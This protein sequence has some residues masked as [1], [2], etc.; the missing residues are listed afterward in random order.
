VG[1]GVL[2]WERYLALD[3][4]IGNLQSALPLEKLAR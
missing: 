3:I 1:R 4:E 2:L